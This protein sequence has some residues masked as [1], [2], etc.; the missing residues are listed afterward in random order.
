M[1]YDWYV[2]QDKTEKGPFAYEEIIHYIES[3]GIKASDLAWTNGMKKWERV[4]Q[5]IAFLPSLQKFNPAFHSSDELYPPPFPEQIEPENRLLEESVTPE[6]PD[7]T[8]R[9]FSPEEPV[10]PGKPVSRESVMPPVK[11]EP[12]DKPVLSPNLEQKKKTSSP[13]SQAEPHSKNE[14]RAVS[15]LPPSPAPLDLETI[16]T[17]KQNQAPSG[18]NGKKIQFILAAALAILVIG[19]G[20]L[21]YDYFMVQPEGIVAEA[22]RNES[23]GE[24][25][26]GE[27]KADETVTDTNEEKSEDPPAEQPSKPR[28]NSTGN[29]AMGGFVAESDGWVYFSMP[30]DERLLMME[31]DGGEIIVL[32]DERAEFINVIDDWVYYVSVTDIVKIRSNGSEREVIAPNAAAMFMSVVDDWIYYFSTID[33]VT[34]SGIYKINL[35]GEE[36]TLLSDARS[37]YLN[38]VDEWLFFSHWGDDRKPYKVNLEGSKLTEL[39]DDAA[40][41][42]QVYGKHLYYSADAINI[43]RVDFDGIEKTALDTDYF[44]SDFIIDDGWL[45]F[46]WPASTALDSYDLF[47]L[48]IENEEIEALQNIDMPAEGERTFI[49]T[50]N[51]AGDWLYLYTYIFG[52]DYESLMNSIYRIRT[53][54]SNF[55]LVLDEDTL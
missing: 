22:E 24:V 6:K 46:F 30:D 11:K 47:R 1:E 29:I 49:S 39:S 53:D 42:I 19:G 51:L 23:T 8:E 55:E 48:N 28:G 14:L 26:E 18:H 50:F 43:H 54:G 7:R 31:A 41:N 37:M 16:A 5:L 25:T 32:A 45:Y 40:F 4:D 3:G 36:K 35:D 34:G 38:V 21:T 33:L 13:A 52:D 10:T 17:E 12:H 15:S 2:F 44:I 9:P 27:E 20:L